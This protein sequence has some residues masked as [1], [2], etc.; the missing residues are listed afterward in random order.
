MTL[1]NSHFSYLSNMIN[2]NSQVNFEVFESR[3]IVLLFE[4]LESNIGYV[5][6]KFITSVAFN[7]WDV[8]VRFIHIHVTS[9]NSFV[10]CHI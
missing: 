3:F 8:T 4:S 1:N 6:N 7:M 9:L 10:G 2:I 5:L